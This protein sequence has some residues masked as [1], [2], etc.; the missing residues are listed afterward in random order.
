M[1]PCAVSVKG[2]KKNVGFALCWARGSPITSSPQWGLLPRALRVWPFPLMS[3]W[4]LL[5]GSPVLVRSPVTWATH[6]SL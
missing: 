6:P 2:K 4:A 1:L 5:I 3:H